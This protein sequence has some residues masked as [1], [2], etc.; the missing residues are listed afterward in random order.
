MNHD[1]W[2]YIQEL[3]FRALMRSSISKH[4]EEQLDR[5]AFE[6]GEGT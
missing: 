1:V 5:I 3:E 4:L 6:L 2:D